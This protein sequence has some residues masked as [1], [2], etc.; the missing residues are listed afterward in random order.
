LA[1]QI[2][3][4]L[5]TKEASDPQTGEALLKNA[6]ELIA[7]SEQGNDFQR[8]YHRPVQESPEVAMAHG[9]WKLSAFR[10]DGPP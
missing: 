1:V 8:E 7:P 3:G 6:R 9:E 10:P 2:D 5:S 4:L